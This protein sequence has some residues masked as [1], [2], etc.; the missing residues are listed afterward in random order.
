[1]MMYHRGRLIKLL[2]RIGVQLGLS[3]KGKA[4]IGVVRY[5]PN[6]NEQKILKQITTGGCRFFATHA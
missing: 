6:S 4:V 5:S 2:I 3:S 1:M